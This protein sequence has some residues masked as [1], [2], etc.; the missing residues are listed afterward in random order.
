LNIGTRSSR[1]KPE[2]IAASADRQPLL[3]NGSTSDTDEDQSD[4]SRLAEM[5][6]ELDSLLN[7]LSS[8]NESLSTLAGS[9]SGT[10]SS[11]L[12]TL[13]RHQDILKVGPKFETSFHVFWS[14]I[15]W[16]T[17]I[18]LTQHLIDR[19]VTLFFDQQLVSCN[20]STLRRVTHQP[21]KTNVLG[22]TKTDGEV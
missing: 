18:T 15:I 12:H 7:Q 19:I 9:Q 6:S 22:V 14:K 3:A 13:Q 17:D 8:L 21:D 20:V 5:T 10:S 16:S 2:R 4:K 11:V 1:P